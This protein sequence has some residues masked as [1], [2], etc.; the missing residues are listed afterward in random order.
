MEAAILR[1]QLPVLSYIIAISC[2]GLLDLNNMAAE[3]ALLSWA[4]I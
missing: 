1:F 3:V 4:E 2:V